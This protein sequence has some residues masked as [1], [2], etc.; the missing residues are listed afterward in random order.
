M[1]AL[2]KLDAF[3]TDEDLLETMAKVD[4]DGNGTL[5][6]PEFAVMMSL[7]KE[8]VNNDDES[9]GP[10]AEALAE[11]ER[12]K[13][14]FLVLRQLLQVDPEYRLEKDVDLILQQVCCCCV[15]LLHLLPSVSLLS[16]PTVLL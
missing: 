7:C 10:R 15:I 1:Q 6:F 16:W 5:S 4:D 2:K 13:Q 11:E 14:P 12:N 3:T 9:E 8:R